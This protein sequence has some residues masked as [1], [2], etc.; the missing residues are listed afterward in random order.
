[1]YDTSGIGCLGLSTNRKAAFI[2]CYCS[3]SYSRPI[4]PQSD[5]E[6]LGF[7]QDATAQ[8]HLTGDRLILLDDVKWK[9]GEIPETTPHK[10]SVRRKSSSK[11]SQTPLS[12]TGHLSDTGVS[13]VFEELG[14]G[15]AAEPPTGA[16][17]EQT[18]EQIVSNILEPV[19][20]ENEKGHA[21]SK[22]AETNGTMTA[23]MQSAVSS[24]TVDSQVI[25]PLPETSKGQFKSFFTF[26]T[27]LYLM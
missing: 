12:I 15:L 16:G 6:V 25:E 1:M 5:S 27:V 8:T 14:S 3:P 13:T 19:D 17:N 10:T 23:N 7:N 2:S 4:S 18:S 22:P 21:E 26:Q 11:L 20:F 24:N 9:W